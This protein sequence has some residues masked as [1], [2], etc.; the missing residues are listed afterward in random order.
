MSAEKSG[1]KIRVA[2]TPTGET[3]IE[4]DAKSKQRP[5]FI[6]DDKID[7]NT[8]GAGEIKPFAPGDQVELGDAVVNIIDD[9]ALVGTL[10]PLIQDV[11]LLE[12]TSSYTSGVAGYPNAWIKD[13]VPGSVD[14]NGNP[15]VDI[16]FNLGG[17]T[18]T[19]A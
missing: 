16:T 13:I 3:K 14:L 8:D 2:F 9:F 18:P 10:R 17:D 4:F 11:G 6:G 1:Y 15:T 7:L 5:S 12:F 19:V